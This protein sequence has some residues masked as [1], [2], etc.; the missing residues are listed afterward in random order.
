MPFKIAFI[1]AFVFA[2]TVATRTAKRATA[3]HG[4]TLNQLVHEVRGLIIVRAALGLVFYAALFCWLFLPSALPWMYVQVPAAVR[5]AAAGLL[6]PVLAFFAS[7]FSTLGTNYRGGVGLYDSHELVTT[8]PYRIV[9]HPI[10]V[11]FIAIMVLVFPLSTNWLLALSGL[12]L[13]VSIAV[14]RGPI[15]DAELR[16]RFGDKWATYQ[17]RTGAF[18]P[19]L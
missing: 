13:V 6:V 8:G 7:A 3:R 17:R 4:G 12:A 18:L 19:R 14:T 5:W 1:I 16:E 15:E 10:Y 9:R 2:A 11:A